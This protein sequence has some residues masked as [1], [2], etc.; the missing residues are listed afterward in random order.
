[1]MNA[2]KSTD[3]R[4]NEKK[5]RF[6]VYS[7][8]FKVIF[9]LKYSCF[10]KITRLFNNLLCKNVILCGYKRVKLHLFTYKCP[11]YRPKWLFLVNN[12]I[13][14]LI[15]FTQLMVA[16]PPIYHVLYIHTFLRTA[17]PQGGGRIS[18]ST[19]SIDRME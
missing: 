6:N 2:V 15:I 1:M 11:S 3:Q 10:L 19:G 4:K 18:S 14:V 16:H 17:Y 13:T 12:C 9:P 5:I 7:S 8:L